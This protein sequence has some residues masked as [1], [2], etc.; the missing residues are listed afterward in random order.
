MSIKLRCPRR[1]CMVKLWSCVDCY[2]DATAF[3]LRPWCEGYKCGVGKLRRHQIAAAYHADAGLAG[4]AWA[5]TDD[6]MDRC[7]N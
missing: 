3:D 7:A 6:E 2:V 4:I 1:G 5:K